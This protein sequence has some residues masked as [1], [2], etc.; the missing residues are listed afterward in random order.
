MKLLF[1]CKYCNKYFSNKHGLDIH[2][3]RE[4]KHGLVR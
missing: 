4:H 3:G 1:I 2:F